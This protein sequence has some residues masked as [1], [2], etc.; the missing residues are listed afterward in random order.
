MAKARKVE[1]VVVAPLF[2]GKFLSRKGHKQASVNS[3]L[4]RSAASAA[5]CT[6]MTAGGCDSSPAH[7]SSS[8]L[9]HFVSLFTASESADGKRNSIRSSEY[10]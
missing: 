7:A 8:I 3:R 4:T 1:F 9:N 2:N 6:L 5:T 10:C